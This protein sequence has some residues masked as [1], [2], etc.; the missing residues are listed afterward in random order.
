MPSR[1][2][3]IFDECHGGVVQRDIT[4]DWMHRDSARANTRRYVKWLLRK[5]Y[6]LPDLQGAAVQNVLK[7][8]EALL[9]K[10]AGAVP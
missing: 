8:D 9:A 1:S 10:W 4:V 7:K 6:Y 3:P 2:D 5:Y